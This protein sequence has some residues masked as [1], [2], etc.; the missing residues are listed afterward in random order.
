MVA[1][2]GA[3]PA[4]DFTK[5]VAPLLTKYCNGCHNDADRE[6]KLS[7]ES[8]ASLLKGGEKGSV[9]TPGQAD[10]SRLVRV[11]TGDAKPKMPPEGEEAPK[12]AEIEVLKAW[13]AAGAKGPS[14][15]SADPTMLV[16]PQV[17]LTAPA[18]PAIN[19]I[20]L[21][22]K[23]DVLG[24]AR[25]GEV[26]L[27]SIPDRKTLHKLAGIRGSVNGVAFSHDGQF[28]VAAAGEPGLVGEA[29]QFKVAD[30]SLVKEFRGHKDSLYCVRLSPDG[31]TLATGG[32][33]NAIKL[34]DVASGKELRTLDAH[35]GAVFE[36]AFRPDGQVLASASGDRTVK[37]WNPATGQRLDTLKDS[38][39]E[40]Y[41]LAFSPD[42][43][44]LAAAG[45]DNRIRVWQITPDAK[46]GTNPLLHSIFA[47]ETPVLRIVWSADGQTIASAGE[48]QLV[49]IWNADDMTI[50]QTLEKQ[51]DWASGLALSAKGDSLVVGRIDGS[52]GDY[53]LAAPSSATDKPLVQ[54][55]EVP[56][57]VDYG[58]QPAFDKLPKVAETEP[59]DQPAQALALPTPGVATGVVFGGDRGL[60]FDQ[61]LCKF[62]AKAGDQWL[63]ETKAAR[64]NSPL[65]TKIE[66]LDSTG[67]PVPR[68]LLRAVRDS[69]IEFRGM[70]GEQRGVRLA[71]WEEMLLNEYVYLSGEVIKHYQQRRGPD[72]DANFYPENGN[73]FAFFDTTCRAHALGE[74]AYIVVPYA[75]G[76]PL[77]NNGLP[78]FTLPYENDDDAHRK[79]GKDSRLTFVAPRDGEYLVRVS[80]VRGF[81]GADFKYEL[82]IRRPQPDFRVTLTGANPNI[83]AGSGKTFTVKAERIDNFMGSIRVDI[84]GLPPGFQATTPLVIPAGLYEAQGVINALP[85]APQP[86]EKDQPPTKVTATATIFGQERTHDVN[87][88]GTIN[89]ADKPKV[90]VHLEPVGQASRLPSESNTGNTAGETPAPRQ[91]LEITITPG[92]TA[93]CNLRIERNGFE[94]RVP[95]DIANLP[96]GIIVDDIGLSGILVR[97]KETE[98]S[99][100]LRAEPWVAEQS[101]TFHATAQVEGNQ[102]SLPMV[103]RVKRN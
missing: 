93:H 39:K 71:N 80:D 21:S 41:S 25:H 90:V 10:L 26:E 94:D 32:Y 101:R 29:R 58:P 86:P 27:Q 30:G 54:L 43:S 87:N 63:I 17:K 47:H 44:R 19:A 1:A 23:G 16:V 11:L 24:I 78:V 57:E 100:V 98:R 97:E 62:T 95:F 22:P 77:P 83:N 103:I 65:D 6:G 51:S 31:K 45:V 89:L 35:N 28:V 9:V 20:A 60:P 14:G 59:N 15:A 7:L 96:H 5:H 18:K 61:D 67:Q 2:Q 56:P 49:K 46:E 79:L 99:F 82:T 50:R 40:L 91:A 72:G 64:M 81:A 92:G 53:P 85:D 36:L 42:G 33:D 4:P 48:D 68:L 38:V 73:R 37:L 84:T 74:P 75:V 102:V 76:T 55:A 69:A 34:W 3:E 66:V 13:I 12:P 88:L 52:L 8:Y 70:N